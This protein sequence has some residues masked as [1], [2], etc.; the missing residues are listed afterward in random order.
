MNTFNAS[1]RLSVQYDWHVMMQSLLGLVLPTNS[2]GVSS[3]L[4][5]WSDR[6]SNTRF[7]LSSDNSSRLLICVCVCTVLRSDRHRR[8]KCHITRVKRPWATSIADLSADFT[9]WTY[10]NDEIV[11]SKWREKS[12]ICRRVMI[13]ASLLVH[14]FIWIY[15]V[16]VVRGP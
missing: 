10:D 2:L 7:Y 4:S 16:R 5:Q 1:G 9:W 6:T 8:L 12:P 11:A 3:R 13:W 14:Y 15:S